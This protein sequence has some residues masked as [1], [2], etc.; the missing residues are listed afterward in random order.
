MELIEELKN[1]ESKYQNE[2]FPSANTFQIIEGELPI[3]ISAPHSVTHFRDGNEKQGE[4]ITGAIAKILQN[5]LNCTCITKIKN[6]RTDPNYDSIHPYKEAIKELVSEKGITLLVD[7]HIMSSKRPA[8]IEI[9]TGKGK[10]IFNNA[11][12]ATILRETFES[13][14][15]G[16]VIMDELFTAGN[17]NTVSSDV[18]RSVKIPCIQIELNWRLLDLSSNHNQIREVLHSLETSIKTLSQLTSK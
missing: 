10:N 3:I 18:S 9:G 1:L 12:L 16:P 15:I 14:L 13:N 6:D 4:F 17:V 2:E 5:R 11:Y 8:A 7:L